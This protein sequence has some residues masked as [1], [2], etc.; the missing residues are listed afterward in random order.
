M[1][2][3]AEPYEV[4]EPDKSLGDLAGELASEFSELV[5]THVEL[6]KWELRQDVRQAA[7]AGAMLGGGAVAAL[8]ALFM[9]SMAAAW[10][11]AE[12]MAP[13]WAFLIVSLLWALAAAVLIL[14]G[15]QQISTMEPGPRATAEELQE[16]KQWLKHQTI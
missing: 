1:T 2:S 11:L 12:V 9:I 16:D 8:I 10:G 14:V 3:E 7:R 6:A 5:K 15:K 13:G 4:R